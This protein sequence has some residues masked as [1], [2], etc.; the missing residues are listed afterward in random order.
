MRFAAS[1]SRPRSVPSTYQASTSSRGMTTTPEASFASAPNVYAT[2]AADSRT[3]PLW[4]ELPVAIDK[5]PWVFERSLDLR[6]APGPEPGVELERAAP[7]AHQRAVQLV[8]EACLGVQLTCQRRC[9]MGKKEPG[10]L[11]L[12]VV[13]L[14]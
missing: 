2:S 8:G 11:V 1:G 12:R 7:S 3:C 4:L 9:C 6:N 10:L 14:V 5:L 13:A